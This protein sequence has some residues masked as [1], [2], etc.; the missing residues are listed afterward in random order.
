MEAILSKI[1]LFIYSV[2]RKPSPVL[3]KYRDL[4][5]AD[6]DQTDYLTQYPAE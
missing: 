1:N 4:Q 5:H 2:L 3:G 6:Q